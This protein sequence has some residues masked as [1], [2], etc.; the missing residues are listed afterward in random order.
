MERKFPERLASFRK[1][2]KNSVPFVVGIFR[3]FKQEFFLE[4]PWK[5]VM[6]LGQLPRIVCEF[7][8]YRLLK[9]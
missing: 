4:A 3:K 1:I 7:P 2:L 9:E 5:R 8:G 6:H